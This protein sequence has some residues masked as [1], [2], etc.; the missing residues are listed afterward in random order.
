VSELKDANP[1][2]TTA[3]AV[4]PQYPTTHSNVAIW[5]SDDFAQMQRV[6][7]VLTKSGLVPE[8]L[9]KDGAEWLP[10]AVIAARCTLVCNQARL[11]GADPLN[12][13]QCTSLING[14]LMYEGKL[15]AAVVSSMTGVRLRYRFGVWNTDHIEFPEDETGLHGVGERLA[16]RC[17]DPEDPDRHVDGSVG[18][19]KTSRKGNPW[20][21][22]NNWTRQLRYRASREW[23]RAYEPGVILGILADGDQD[24]DEIVLQAKPV[25]LMQRLKGEQEGNGFNHEQVQAQ[26]P[27][28]RGRPPK[29]VEPEETVHAAAE[30]PDPAPCEHEWETDGTVHTCKK[31]GLI[32]DAG[33]PTPPKTEGDAPTTSPHAAPDEVY[34]LAGDGYNNDD[35]RMTY[36]NGVRFSTV[37]KKSEGKFTEYAVHAPEKPSPIGDDDIPEHMRDGPSSIEEAREEYA[38]GVAEA[39][40]ATEPERPTETASAPP[41]E[42]EPA[43]SETA[44]PASA[45][46]APPE[47]ASG[48]SPQAEPSTP[49]E[50]APATIPEP[51]EAYG[52]AIENC[53]SWADVLD[54]LK[55]FIGSEFFKGLPP[56]RQNR[57]RGATWGNLMDIGNFKLP[58]PVDSISAFRLWLEHQPDPDAINGTADVLKRGEAWEN[59]SEGARNQINNAVAVR[60]AALS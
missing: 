44:P 42:A 50:E 15:I 49:A 4:R 47:T 21:N 34:L 54:V 2:K 11:W 22:A 33:E 37:H 28:R 8:T 43:T 29:N 58:D 17:F 56:E 6:A 10:E 51:L 48:P 35:R 32:D 16:V 3:V 20:E 23:A 41:A 5:D 60:L 57:I 53:A 38:A 36:K 31:C 55:G 45:A 26:T 59:A 13:L 52:D 14:R 25:G 18:L 9:C 7:V 27:K 12:V 39:M 19:W 46:G 30:E 24:I 40:G 1:E